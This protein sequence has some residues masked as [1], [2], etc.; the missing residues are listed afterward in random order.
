M[1]NT[2]AATK[3]TK[4]KWSND[5]FCQLSTRL[6]GYFLSK[7]LSVHD[8]KESDTCYIV[9]ASGMNTCFPCPDCGS[10]CS[11]VHKYYTRTLDSLELWGSRVIIKFRSRY[12]YCDC[13]DCA[14]RTFSEPLDIAA[15]YARKSHEVEKRIIQTSLNLSSRK[16]SLLLKGQ[17]IHASISQCTRNVKSLGKS[18]PPCKSV[19]VGIDDFASKK[20]HVYM[21]LACDHDTSQPVAVFNSRYGTELNRWLKDNE[22]IVLVTRD[23]SRDYARAISENLPRAIQVS[24]RFHLIKNLFAGVIDSIQKMLYQSNGKLPYPYPSAEEAYGYMFTELC[25]IGEKEHREKVNN[26]LQIKKMISEGYTRL[27]IAAEIGKSTSYI[28]KLMHG[29][30]FLYYLDSEQR[31]GMKYLSEMAGILS[32]GTISLPS[33]VKRME[34]KL[35]SY[36]VSRMMRTIEKVYTAKRKLV[37]EHNTKL[38]KGKVKKK[39]PVA[40][41]REAILKGK[42][43]NEVLAKAIESNRVVEQVINLCIEFR[44][45]IKGKQSTNL[46][47]W[48]KKAKKAGN[49]SLVRFAYNIEAD[50]AAVQSAIETEYSNAL[51][52]GEVNRVKSIKRT[53][54]NK[55]GIE[56]LRAKII[57]GL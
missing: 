43:K 15:R 12:Y 36:M 27:E 23:G 20:G 54:F 10:V 41:I 57:Y 30:N 50:K 55:A 38:K 40:T 22:Q 1:I 39:V 29:R 13:P 46:D 16:S 26:Y 35:D 37:R 42:T 2:S 7:G 4:K 3:D 51:M 32:G 11:H 24:D 8:F 45:M 49:Y 52:E 19:H 53:M 14:R 18:N 9:Y 48:I 44:E 33:M 56:L 34:G 6:R 21:C 31:K 28:Y 25:G 5:P 17:N 47:E